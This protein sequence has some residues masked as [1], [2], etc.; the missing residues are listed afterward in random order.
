M[1][2]HMSDNEITHVR[3]VLHHD[4][5]GKFYSVFH[6]CY[7]CYTSV[8]HVWHVFHA[9]VKHLLSHEIHMCATPPLHM[10][11]FGKGW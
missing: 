6:M 1:R 4:L 7:T 3:H 8:T 10:C 9:C 2:V 5:V 11:S